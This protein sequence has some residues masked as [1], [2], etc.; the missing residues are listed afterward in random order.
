MQTRNILTDV[1][2]LRTF[3]NFIQA[4]SF[5]RSK[6][7]S[8]NGRIQL[9]YSE[10]SHH[11]HTLCKLHQGTSTAETGSTYVYLDN[12][13]RMLVSVPSV[14]LSLPQSLHAQGLRDRLWATRVQ[15]QDPL[16]VPSSLHQKPTWNDYTT[17]EEHQE[18]SSYIS[19]PV[20]T[21]IRGR[22]IKTPQRFKDY[23]MQF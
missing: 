4:T 1:M 13:D 12:L 15:Q 19:N 14:T 2:E 3:Q 21:T 17:P 23:A 22:R 18:I 6:T 8:V 16:S 20:K 7:M 9:Q 5:C 10:K 11:I